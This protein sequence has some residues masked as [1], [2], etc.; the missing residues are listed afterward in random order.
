MKQK[1]TV[2]ALALTG[3]IILAGSL[4]SVSAATS[5]TGFA[6]VKVISATWYAPDSQVQVSPNSSYVPLFV[7]IDDTYLGS[8][9]YQNFSIDLGNSGY[10]TYSYVNGPDVPYADFQNITFAAS[11][12]ATSH[13][14]TL[15]QLVNISSETPR[16]IYEMYVNVTTNLSSGFMHIPFQVAVLATPQISMVNYFTNPPVIYQDEKYI[17]LTMVFAN[18][19]A[20]PYENFN[21]SV[22]SQDFTTL[23]ATYHIPYFAP[24]TT[25]NITFLLDAHNVTGNAILTINYGKYSRELSLYIH[26]HDT[27]SV[28]STLGTL[29]PGATK[30]VE[31]FNITNEGNITMYDITIHLLSPSVISIHVSSSNPL[32]ALT[33]DNVTIGELLPGQQATITFLVDV[34]SSAAVQS[35]PAQLV[36]QWYANNSQDQFLQVYNFAEKVTPTPVQQIQDS[37]KFT[38]LNIVVLVVIVALVV[39]L[40]IV[41]SRGRRLSRE[42]GK[43]EKNERPSLEHRELPDE[44]KRE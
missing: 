8:A 27:L 9:N 15:E 39:S 25:E 30:V 28:S 12:N 4:A 40:V 10:F 11:P 21:V 26:G 32:S 34:S 18:T 35:Y 1:G 23:T 44:K 38:P 5:A 22:T 29:Q 31:E 42:A 20:G 3:L 16:G 17:T 41:A 33:A 36:I 13:T 19:G 2:L 43:N 24:G 37:F 7:T 14:I 6:E